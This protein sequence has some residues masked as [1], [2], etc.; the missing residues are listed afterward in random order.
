MKAISDLYI[1]LVIDGPDLDR[2]PVLAPVVNDLLDV[3]VEL[4]HHETGQ[5]RLFPLFLDL[6]RPLIESPELGVR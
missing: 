4:V 3:L 5:A 2:R 6:L 1:A